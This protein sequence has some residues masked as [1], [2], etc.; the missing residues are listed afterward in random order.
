MPSQSSWQLGVVLGRSHVR[1]SAMKCSIL[2]FQTM[3][4]LFHN[5]ISSVTTYIITQSY[6]IEAVQKRR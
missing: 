3:A 6:I 4:A 5:L 2:N 1:H